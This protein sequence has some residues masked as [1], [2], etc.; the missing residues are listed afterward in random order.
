M[1]G[2][3]LIIY[4]LKNDLEQSDVEFILNK[5]LMSSRDYA[6]KEGAGVLGEYS[7]KAL[8]EMRKLPGVKI[9]ENIYIL[10]GGDHAE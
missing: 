8:Y 2:K 7:V 3:D 6:A 1:N 4:I 5:L 9:G 10:V